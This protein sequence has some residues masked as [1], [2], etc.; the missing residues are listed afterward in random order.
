[1]Y[2]EEGGKGWYLM[3]AIFSDTISVGQSI[4]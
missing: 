3:E 2:G 4:Q 1:V